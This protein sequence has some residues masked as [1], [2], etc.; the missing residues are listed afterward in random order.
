MKSSRFLIVVLA[1][2]LV[3]AC[4]APIGVK[5]VDPR[6]VQRDLTADVL[7]LLASRIYFLPIYFDLEKMEI[8]IKNT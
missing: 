8:Q 4:A 1:A 7:L 2:A 5:R 6:E 3:G